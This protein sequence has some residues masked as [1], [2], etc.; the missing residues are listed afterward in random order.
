MLTRDFRRLEE[1]TRHS[2]K[3]LFSN[4]F[5]PR[6]PSIARLDFCLRRAALYPAELRVQTDWPV[7]TRKRYGFKDQNDRSTICSAAPTPAFIQLLQGHLDGDNGQAPHAP[8]QGRPN[9]NPHPSNPERFGA[10]AGPQANRSWQ[11]SSAEIS[12]S[13]SASVL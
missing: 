8:P 5:L 12:A 6:P 13:T 3:P 7:H 1:Q 11:S 2:L 10:N 4:F 9:S